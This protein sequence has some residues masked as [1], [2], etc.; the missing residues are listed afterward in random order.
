[1]KTVTLR[2]DENS[3]MAQLYINDKLWREGNFWDFN[4]IQDIPFLLS[5]LGI[6]CVEED[7]EYFDEEDI[8]EDEEI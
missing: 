2:T 6:D 3:E 7:Y 4:F 5:K 8:E 1:M